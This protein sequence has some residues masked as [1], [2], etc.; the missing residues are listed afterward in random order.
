VRQINKPERETLQPLIEARDAAY[1]AFQDAETALGRAVSKARRACLAP[2]DA[3]LDDSSF[4]WVRQ[5]QDQSGRV[6]RT[7]LKA[8]E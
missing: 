4:E 8:D 6:R 7:A 3:V 1:A 2:A 5:E